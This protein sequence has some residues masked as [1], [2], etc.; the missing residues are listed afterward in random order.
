MMRHFVAF[1][2]LLFV[3]EISVEASNSVHVC[4]FNNGSECRA[5]CM[6]ILNCRNGHCKLGAI[7]KFVQMRCYCEDC[8]GGQ[9]T[10]NLPGA[11]N[12]AHI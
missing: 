2:L 5:R 11:L 3:L 9:Q 10:K 8:P 6:K 12:L 7:G 1:L 4:Y